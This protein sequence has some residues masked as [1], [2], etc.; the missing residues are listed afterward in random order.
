MKILITGGHITPALAVIEKLI[1]T[2][3]DVQII[4]AGR[5][6]T[7]ENDSSLSWEYQLITK[8]PRVYFVNLITGRYRRFLSFYTIVSFFKIPVGIV[9]SAILLNNKKPDA[10]LTF[11]GYLG[12]PVVFAA[13]LLGIPVVAHEQTFKKGL[14]NKIIA[15]FAKK[16]CIS[17]ESSFKEYPKEKTVLTGNPLRL[18]IFHFNSK[19]ILLKARQSGL[20]VIYITGGSQ[21]S[22]FINNLIE[23]NLAAILNSYVLIH[24]CG[25]AGN[26]EDYKKLKSI[27]NS[28]PENLKDRYFLLTHI[29]P[30]DIGTVYQTCD[31]VIGRSGVNTVWELLALGKK[32]IFIPLPYGQKEEQYTN[33]QFA[34]QNGQAAVLEQ[35][36]FTDDEFFNAIREMLKKKAAKKETRQFNDAAKKIVQEVINAV[37][38]KN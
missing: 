7:T 25:N 31:L 29:F 15:L 35:G 12:V 1:Q 34:A 32:A 6:T 36:K 27:A 4:F 11:G 18:E 16:I 21:G 30:K 5:K 9:Q 17:S 24:Q 23:R 2:M 26:L 3:P 10:V 19:S 28:L 38:Q 37:K 13:R 20:P 33:A 8:I 22:R 14:A